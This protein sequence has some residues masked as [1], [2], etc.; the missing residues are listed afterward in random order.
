MVFNKSNIVQLTNTRK[1]NLTAK[2]F[3]EEDQ[4]I[5]GLVQKTARDG[6]FSVICYELTNSRCPSFKRRDYSFFAQPFDTEYIDPKIGIEVLR[7]YE[8]LGFQLS[9]TIIPYRKSLES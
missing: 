1:Q 2:I 9:L 4:I 7:K 8:A 3:R 5:K 6:E